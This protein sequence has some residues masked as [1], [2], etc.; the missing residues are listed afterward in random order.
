MVFR[1]SCTLM[2]EQSN[3]QQQ[4]NFV[5]LSCT[6]DLPGGFSG[7]GSIELAPFTPSTTFW[8]S[9]NVFGFELE[10][11]IIQFV[12]SIHCAKITVGQAKALGSHSLTN[13]LFGQ[14]AVFGTEN[15]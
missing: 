12:S 1:A 15:F 13:A 3:A 10:E 2:L 8:G 11:L 4:E 7:S 5:L 6:H 14:L 9:P